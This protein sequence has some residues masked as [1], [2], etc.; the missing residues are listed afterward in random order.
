MRF[1]HTADIHLDSPLLSLNR[2]EGAPVEAFRSAT[3]QAFENL[4]ELAI[5][6]DVH[7]VLI[8]GDLYD[9]ECKDMNTPIAFRRCL[10]QLT[11]RGIRVFIVQG[12]HDA[13]SKV[14]K[15]F[16]LDLPD[17]VTLF[18]T[19]K[20]E[21][22]TFEVD[23]QQVAIHGQ[24]FATAAVEENLAAEYPDALPHH[25]NIGLLHTNCGASQGH[26]DYAPSTVPQLTTKNYDYWALGHIHQR[27]NL[28]EGHPWIVYPGNI[29]G[30]H[31]RETGAKGCCLVT[32]DEGDVTEVAFRPVDVMR[33]E[34]LVL[35]ATELA[36]GDQVVSAVVQAISDR[37]AS[38]GD[39]T[40]AVRVEV[41][42]ATRAHGDLVL[43]TGHFDGRIREAVVERLDEQV[44]I[45]KIRLRTTLVQDAGDTGLGGDAL[46]EFLRD[47]DEAGALDG[48]FSDVRAELEALQAAIPTDPRSPADLPDLDQEQTR[49]ELLDAARQLLVPRLLDQGEDR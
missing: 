29:Q 36:N 6:E 8:A 22:V 1:I 40:L 41:T 7:F 39:L 28:A 45:E 14:S 47:L 9:G 11:D 26:G 32:V 44:W 20:A 2:Y 48:A 42:G 24:G 15:A 19:R 10:R 12:N 25:L 3:R 4:V 43:H 38:I 13:Q 35:D 33:W 27:Q 46:G 18:S 34:E 23:G 21:T 17:M 31:I 49:L 37:L 5:E 30:R 16:R